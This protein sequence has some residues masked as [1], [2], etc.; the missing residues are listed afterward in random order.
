[1]AELHGYKGD[2]YCLV[3]DADVSRAW[4]AL[5]P[6]KSKIKYFAPTQRVAERLKLYGV[7]SSNIFYTGF[8]LPK[9]SK[10]DF[11]ARMRNLDPASKKTNFLTLM[12]GRKEATY[13]S[14]VE[15]TQATFA[16]VLKAEAKIEDQKIKKQSIKNL[17]RRKKFKLIKFEVHCLAWLVSHRKL[18][19][20][21]LLPMPTK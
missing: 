16:D 4:V 15:G 1:M 20:G 3:A 19:S 21:L 18:N 14:Q 6:K 11:Q 7:K 9:T 8:P 13:S 17:P 5:N 10:K 2:I 12:F